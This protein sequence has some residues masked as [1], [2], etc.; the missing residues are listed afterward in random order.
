M[1]STP[2]KKNIKQDSKPEPA[3]GS[4][5]FSDQRTQKQM[6]ES[7]GKLPLQERPLPK[8]DRPYKNLKSY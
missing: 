5:E 1:K 4:P 8:N 2:L 6:W 3:E 7:S